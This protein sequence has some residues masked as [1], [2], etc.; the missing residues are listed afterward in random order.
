MTAP[1]L[2]SFSFKGSLNNLNQDYVGTI[3]ESI[4]SIRFP[5]GKANQMI[6]SIVS[7]SV[8]IKIGDLT[9][10]DQE[11]VIDFSKNQTVV[12]TSASGIQKT[13]TITPYFLTP[14]ADTGQTK[15]YV[16]DATAAVCSAVT[17]TMANQDGELQ[18]FPNAKNVQLS[19]TT[20]N[21]PNDPINID[22]LKGIV[23]KTCHQG[24]TGNSCTGGTFTQYTY[25]NAVT[26]CD[27]LNS[28]NSG[29]GYAGLKQWRLPTAQELNQ[30]MEHNTAGTTLHWN[31]TYFPNTPST[32][33]ANM[34][35]WTSSLLLPAANSS[36]ALN[37]FLTVQLLSG[38]NPVHCV[39][40]VSPPSFDLKDNGDGTV[41]DNRTLL[42]W[43]KCSAGQT[44]DANCTGS[45]STDS[46]SGAHQ[47][48]KNLTLGSRSWRLPNLNEWLSLLDMSKSTYYDT[49]LFPNMSSGTFHSSSTL[50]S[51]E[52]Y[53]HL[54]VLS[55]PNTQG[56]S[57]K[58]NNYN[59]KC[60]SGP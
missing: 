37:E 46:W 48:C 59:I 5:Y 19:T 42:V 17:A 20:T 22:T 6:P 2:T 50:T 7:D 27:N 51:N 55:I 36:L 16:N 52:Y 14:V 25:A 13:Y 43:Q 39:N 53:N 33:G 57:G 15:C 10:K 29:Q 49:V 23:W 45:L 35:R 32:A 28:V 21:Y 31:T 47:Y 26:Q 8:S 24:L 34:N 56:I 3:S 11:T 9:F 30:L 12:L 40:G 18:N 1:T 38:T 44:N 41:T 58:P 54:L 60:V 4:I